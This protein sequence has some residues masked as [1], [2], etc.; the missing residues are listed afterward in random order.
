MKKQ[1]ATGATTNHASMESV[2]RRQYSQ[3]V[4][5]LIFHMSINAVVNMIKMQLVMLL[6]NLSGNF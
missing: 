1:E 3:N 5:T 4:H 2:M 6:R